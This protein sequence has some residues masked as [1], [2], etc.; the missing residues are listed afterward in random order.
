M[1]SHAGFNS[2]ASRP[3]SGI[4]TPMSD[5]SL[6]S[7]NKTDPQ[8]IPLSSS[9]GSR[10]RKY[11]ESALPMEDLLKS[12]I[13]IK[14]HPSSIHVKPGILQPL[15]LLPREHLPLSALDLYTPHGDFSE[16]RFYESRIKILELEGRLGSN[17]LLARSETKRVVYAIER[18]HDGLYTLCKLGPW[19]DM[20]VLSQSATVICS[21]RLRQN[22]P[23]FRSNAGPLPLTTPQLH[24]ENKKRRLAIE[25]IHSLVKKRARSQS[26]APVPSGEQ[27]QCILPEIV[28]PV[29]Q[30][31]PNE[32]SSES[33]TA[34]P[35]QSAHLTPQHGSLEATS[36]QVTAEGIFENIR[37]SYVEALYH[38][39]GSLAYFAKGPLSRARAA[40]H[41]DCES[42][43][44]MNDLI[45]FLKSL[46]M[47]TVVIDKKYR[48]TMP[49][50]VA[51]MKT[52]VED[53]DNGDTKSK[54][55][56]T[57]KM[58]LGKDGL[59]PHE[60]EHICRWWRA[61]KPLVSEEKSVTPN[62]V[63]YHISCLRRRETQLQ[64]III[65]E[66]L[67]LEPLTRPRDT[68]EDSQLPGMESQA[69]PSQTA[70]EPAVKKR[71]K[72]N[73]PVL[74]DVHA[75]RLCIW[76]STIPDEMKILAETQVHSQGHAADKSE[77]P[78]SDALKDFCVDIILPFFSARLPDICDSI[79]RKLGGPVI[80]PPPKP[81]QA[82]PASQPKAKPGAPAKKPT[83]LRRD[84]EK[85]LERVLSNERLRRSVSRG[86]T[87]ALAHM[88]SAS[89]TTIPG[90]KR[91]ASEPLLGMI[92][93]REPPASLREQSSN[94]F[95]RS[96]STS[97]VA[98]E[99]QKAKKKAQLEAEL[100]EAISALKRPN[101]AMV[102]KEIV[103]ET[104]HRRA[105]TS[106]SQLKKSKKP[107]R[108]PAFGRTTAARAIQV[109]ATPANN[110]FKDVIVDESKA[111]LL[112]ALREEEVVKDE[113]MDD[114]DRI[115]ASSSVV[116][117]S[118]APRRVADIFHYS[119]PAVHATPV[120]GSK[121]V[122]ATPARPAQAPLEP[123]ANLPLSPVLAR[124]AAIQRQS[125]HL[126]VSSSATLVGSSSAP[127]GKVGMAAG[128]IFETPLKPRSAMGEI[129]TPVRP[130]RLVPGSRAVAS[131]PELKRVEVIKEQPEQQ[132]EGALKTEHQ[133]VSIYQQ[134]GW[135]DDYD[136]D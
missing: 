127:R 79:N 36:S 52:F 6:N 129:C 19:V 43:L 124:K 71:S 20:E 130:L 83:S 70:A 115:P 9:S 76:Q 106:L 120:A 119:S 1:S 100:K 59:Y 132:R 37:N 122:Q 26:V 10:K 87:S 64:M 89:A 50:I 7:L 74:L 72:H 32:A 103:E 67:A 98:T 21:Q 136:L 31:P 49:E 24:K 2:D 60:A 28:P 46:A 112:R 86:P 111:Q 15:M 48:E 41:L 47:T 12:T 97:S 75:D 42:N 69:G 121:L 109:K 25:E 94:L 18:Q 88:R 40:F 84:R 90:L 85:T 99:E 116:P 80:K 13:V 118:A 101:R 65:M 58:K 30:T 63:K 125:A 128:G 51:K 131:T 102:G 81:T 33:K 117:S 53:S 105:S 68:A 29:E 133:P 4:L 61:N 38:S 17:L 77:R 82:K 57:K 55:R 23:V 44:D 5:G 8:D 66:I 95:S 54:K 96:S 39:M 78:N 45:D 3:K 113:H 126:A 123:D 107:V 91:E 16:S 35:Q 56:K 134:L 22:E 34:A 92:P 93:K 73:F 114:E 108:D 27:A 11:D 62:E 110:R 104:E 135:D 14:P